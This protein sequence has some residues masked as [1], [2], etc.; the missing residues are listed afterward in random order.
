M[1]SQYTVAKFGG[2]SVADY[3][4]MHRCAQIIN[5]DSLVRV[6]VVS[7]SAGVTNH[8]VTLTQQKAD[9]VQRQQLVQAVLDIQNAILAKLTLDSDLESGFE[10]TIAE[11]KTLAALPA[12]SAQQCDEMLSFGERLSSYL[13]TQV[14]RN[15]GINADRFDVR[16]VLKTDNRFGKASPDIKATEKAAQQHL[17]PLLDDKVLVTQ[18]FIGSDVYGQTTTL[19]RGGSDYSAALLAEAIHA[20]SVHIWTDVVGIFSTD[21]RLCA[22][23]S[24]IA[25][26]SFDE[27]A[28]MATFGA[29]VLHPA[30]ILPASRSGIAVFVGSSRD[31]QA[32][33]TWIEREK[34]TVPGIRAVTQRKNQILLTLKS[35]EMLLA[36]GFLARIFTILSA[37]N[38]S[39]DL[40]TTSEISVA[41]TLDNA[42]NASRPE[43]EQAC[44][45]EL[46]EFCHVTV[47]NNLTLVA[48]IGSEIQLK[49]HEMNLMKVLSEFNIRLICHGASKHNLCFLVEQS[50]SD[51][52]VQSIHE[53]LLES[54]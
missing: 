1:N 38:I 31:P 23:A 5:D 41:I 42:Q 25:R 50:H 13:F 43:L 9:E 32:G 15:L 14:L 36:S 46:S 22:K 4:A 52:V 34:S 10:Q 39:V 18:G 49:Q 11:F 20:K 29:K 6:V 16:T 37:H 47:E 30:T 24:P 26:L 48:L 27:A 33:G 3:P 21:P 8:L 2:T 51:H 44:L 53:K 28:E 35:P 12:L 19:G 17:V 45:D 40:V 7:A 54:A